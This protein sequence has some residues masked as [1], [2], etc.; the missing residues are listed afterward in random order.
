MRLW[1]FFV[2][3]DWDYVKK[4]TLWHYED[5]IK[6]LNVLMSYPVLWKAYNQDMNQS[7]VFARGLFPDKSIDAGESPARL[8]S[9]FERLKSAGISDW[10]DLLSKVST[11]AECTAFI[12]E[13]DLIYEEFIDVLNYL[14]RWGFP[15]ET[16]SREL[17]E[18]DSPKE[19]ANYEVLKK[20]KLMKSFDI[21]EQG[22]TLPG[23]KTLMKLT[24]LPLEF[25]TKLAHRADIARL[26]YVRRKTILPV[27]SAGYDT[28][29]KIVG[30]DLAQM[31]SDLDTYFRG[32][33]G[34][35]WENY[36]AVIA[37]KILVRYAKALPVIME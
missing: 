9:T 2:Q 6:K 37:L 16:S 19:M 24:G 22:H 31:D 21:L 11:R 5:L 13:H 27:C 23:R 1:R 14:L 15:F 33:Q 10:G 8:L 4:T 25:L 3:P 35:S 28:L 20:N 32:M 12:V 7:A 18:H 17:V 30:A 26:P 36:K 29:A 34:K